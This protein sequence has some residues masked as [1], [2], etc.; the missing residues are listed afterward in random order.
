MTT[1][2]SLL[3][4][5]TTLEQ[6]HKI[7]LIKKTKFLIIS[8]IDHNKD[9]GF[10]AIWWLGG[11][12]FTDSCTVLYCCIEYILKYFERTMYNSNF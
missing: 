1:K 7:Y 12:E 4:V 5:N 6:A 2:K 9:S 8:I 10:R 11:A 3:P